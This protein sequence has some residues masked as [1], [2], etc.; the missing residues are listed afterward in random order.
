ML[1]CCT[2]AGLEIR[3]RMVNGIGDLNSIPSE[4]IAGLLS[5]K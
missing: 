1:V 4:Y 3:R 2:A 5:L